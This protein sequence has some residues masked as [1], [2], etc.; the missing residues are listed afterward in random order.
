MCGSL[1]LE[2]RK[3]TILLPGQAIN[4]D[5]LS[6]SST[7][8]I[9]ESYRWT[10]HARSDGSVDGTKTLKDQWLSRG[11]QPATIKG[12]ELFTERRKL[13]DGEMQK[14]K[15]FL[16]RRAE[17]GALVNPQNGELVILTR[18]AKTETEKGIHHRFPVY[19]K[20][21]KIL[22]KAISTRFSEK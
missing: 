12:V 3:N 21:L 4:R 15:I 14:V 9:R 11:Y 22:Q 7:A 18:P 20:D 13:P 6:L 16:H 2:H 5:E 10:G 1:R 17:I 8:K 19:V